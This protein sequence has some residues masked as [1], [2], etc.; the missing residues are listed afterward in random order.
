M[1]HNTAIVLLVTLVMGVSPTYAA[2]LT[3]PASNQHWME[4]SPYPSF[5]LP[6]LRITVGVEV[7]LNYN[8]LTQ[9]TDGFIDDTHVD[10]LSGIS[11]YC[12]AICDMAVTNSVGIQLRAGYDSKTVSSSEQYMAKDKY[13][14]R[15]D[16]Q[17]LTT[18]VQ[19]QR[20]IKEH[21]E[22]YS[23][24][25]AWRW[26]PTRHSMMTMGAVYL[27]T[28]SAYERVTE[29]A[30]APIYAYG[31]SSYHRNEGAIVSAMNPHLFG[32]QLTTGYT[33]PFDYQPMLVISTGTQYFLNSPFR[34]SAHTTV[35]KKSV[36][37]NT[38][39]FSV[40]F[41]LNLYFSL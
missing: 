26:N 19:I 15:D 21:L 17:V 6:A 40:Q 2:M 31:S 32:I 37:K 22:Y 24:G 29:R 23:L 36:L 1:Q 28:S 25:L 34:E 12:L 11:Q 7:G 3:K 33:I 13:W 30:T 4:P 39:L 9:S 41:G 20:S 5:Y 14:R 27:L 10:N 38:Y 18:G 16:N 8:I 35:N